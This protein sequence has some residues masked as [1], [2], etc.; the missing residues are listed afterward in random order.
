MDKCSKLCQYHSCLAIRSGT[1]KSWMNTS[2]TC[3][4]C[5][6]CRR[7][8]VDWIAFSSETTELPICVQR[9]VA[10]RPT[11]DRLAS[12]ETTN[13]L[14]S[15][16]NRRMDGSALVNQ[17]ASK[18]WGEREEGFL[19]RKVWPGKCNTCDQLFLCYSLPLPQNLHQKQR[20]WERENQNWCSRD[21]TEL[22]WTDPAWTVLALHPNMSFELS[23]V[24]ENKNCCWFCHCFRRWSS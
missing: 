20:A 21:R 13:K 10:A 22:N 7:R 3:C 19:R 1:R 18:F 14:A 11:S 5:C 16:R 8:R 12:Q 23:W 24:E 17:M 4:C 15:G 6:C 9:H 2:G